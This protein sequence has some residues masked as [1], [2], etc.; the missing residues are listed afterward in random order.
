MRAKGLNVGRAD[1]TN[2]DAHDSE[3]LAQLAL[4]LIERRDRFVRNRAERLA[5]AQVFATLAV[6]KALTDTPKPRTTV[7]QHG[8]YQPANWP[9]PVPAASGGK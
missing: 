7:D 3:S 4:D 5:L 6:Q 1:F 8:R 9:P 2:L